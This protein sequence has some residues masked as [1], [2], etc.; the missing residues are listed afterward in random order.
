[1][2]EI[3]HKVDCLARSGYAT[4]PRYAELLKAIIRQSDLT[5]YD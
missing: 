3:E 1:M 2:K 4:D 5:Q